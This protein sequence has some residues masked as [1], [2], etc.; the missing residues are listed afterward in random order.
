MRYLPLS[1]LLFLM[2]C[3][4]YPKENNLKETEITSKEI[5]NPYF[6]DP[7]RDYVYKARITLQKKEFGGIFIAKKLGPDWHR[8]VVTTELGSKFLDFSFEGDKFI[9]NYLLPEMDKKVLVNTL[10]NDFRALITENPQVLKTFKK[11]DLEIFETKSD[12][13]K[14]Y[15]FYTDDRL[16]K[17][18]WASGKKEKA[19]YL[20]LEAT[21]NLAKEIQI[22]HKNIPLEINLKTIK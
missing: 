21:G 2:A 7:S 12:K 19:E 5:G 14:Y 20:F 10:K 16:E 22:I 6:S 1:F 11:N 9:V 17:I 8:V 15:Y 4:S 3:G 13:K 18:I